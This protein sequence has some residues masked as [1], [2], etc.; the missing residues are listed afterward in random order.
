[1]A[2]IDLK[3]GITLKTID[4]Q[5]DRFCLNISIVDGQGNEAFTG[6]QRYDG[7][8]AFA[9][10]G[11]KKGCLDCTTNGYVKYSSNGLMTSC[12]FE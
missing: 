9:V 11:I 5:E 6:Q 2:D 3:K 12:A 1:V 4:T 7:F 10:D 8:F